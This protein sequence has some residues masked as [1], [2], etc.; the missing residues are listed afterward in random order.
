VIANGVLGPFFF[1]GLSLLYF[2]QNARVTA[3]G[4]DSKES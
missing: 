4:V 2:E 3:R 1:F